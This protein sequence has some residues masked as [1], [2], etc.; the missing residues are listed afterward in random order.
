MIQLIRAW[1][2]LRLEQLK[3]GMNKK[4]FT[5]SDSRQAEIAEQIRTDGVAVLPDYF[6]PQKCDALI[7]EISRLTSGSEA[8][9]WQ[10]DTQS[11]TR[12]YGSHLYSE[13]I[14]EY[15]DDPFLAEIGERY[16]NSELINSHTLGARLIAKESNLGSGGGWHRD[17]VFRTQYKSIV[18][19]TDVTERNGPFEYL[20]GSHR[21]STILTS[22]RRNGFSSHQNRI[23]NEQ[24]ADV[25]KTHPE[26][27]SKVFTAKRGTVVLVDTSGIHRGQPIQEGERYSLTNYFYPLHHYDAKQ[28]EK[29][30]KLF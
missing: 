14:K 20:L 25:L 10:D 8:H 19:L 21:K 7:A 12:V 26:L 16:L 27:K 24:V 9:I 3:N 30:E 6:L 13:A 11:D 22:I 17:S 29:F 5:T 2:Y 23:S 4:P 1:G 15:Y 28:R 18:Y